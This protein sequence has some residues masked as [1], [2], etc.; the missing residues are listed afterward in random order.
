MDKFKKIRD[1]IFDA[2]VNI[3]T[4]NLLGALKANALE[5]RSATLES[6]DRELSIEKHNLVFIGTIGSG[7]TTALCYILGL[8]DD[9]NTNNTEKHTFSPE[10]LVTGSGGSTICEVH[11]LLNKDNH[12]SIKTEFITKEELEYYVD[13]F[14]DF[15]SS[16]VE[17]ENKK[18][19]ALL[20]QEITRALR[21]ILNLKRTESTDFAIEKYKELG[22]RIL[23]KKFLLE[24]IKS[25]LE[26][27]KQLN[28][29]DTPYTN[30]EFIKET[31]KLINSAALPQY[32]IPK[33]ITILLNFE[34]F[35]SNHIWNRYDKVID[36]K[37]L[38]GPF[39]RPDIEKYFKKSKNI[40]AFTSRFSDA[41]DS[42]IVYQIEKC[43]EIIKPKSVRK[44]KD[45]AA[46]LVLPRNDEPT[47]KVGAEGDYD[48]GLTLARDYISS[49]IS[50]IEDSIKDEN[51]LFF[52]A[53]K[54][55]DVKH[56]TKNIIEN[57]NNITIQSRSKDELI[58][59]IDSEIDSIT[60]ITSINKE[61][62]NS[63]IN[64]L[65]KIGLSEFIVS[66]LEFGKLFSEK[67][68]EWYPHWNTKHAINK[69]KGVWGEY[70]VFFLAKKVFM[71]SIS[72]DL[73]YKVSE[74]NKY[75]GEINQNLSPLIHAIDDVILSIELSKF[76]IRLEFSFLDRLV[77][78]EF[79]PHKDFWE[80]LINH[81]IRGHGYTE[82]VLNK[83][84]AQLSK[85]L[86]N[87]YQKLI[88]EKWNNLIN[89][90]LDKLGYNFVQSEVEH[91]LDFELRSFQIQ[92]FQGIN[93]TSQVIIPENSKCI[94]L[95]GE[96]GYGKTSILRGIAAGFIGK[97]E[98][99]YLLVESETTEIEINYYDRLK[100]R[101]IST[102][103]DGNSFK[104]IV[105]YG[106]NRNGLGGIKKNS[107][108]Y[109]LFYEDGDFINI[110]E[111]LMKLERGNEEQIVYYTSIRK[112]LLDFLEDYIDDIY[113]H[114]D[115]TDTKVKYKEKGSNDY[116]G[117]EQLATGFKSVIGLVGDIIWRLAKNNYANLRALSGIVIIDEFDLHLH[118]KW[119]KNILIKLNKTF[120]KVQ[121]IISTHS[122][123]PFLG[124]PINSTI[125]EIDRDKNANITASTL[126]N[127]DFSRLQP[128]AI[129][130]S[131]IFKF[132]S[133]IPHS[134]QGD[135]YPE[136]ED[137]HSNID[138]NRQLEN[139][140]SE[141][142]DDERTKEIL[143]AI[144][145]SDD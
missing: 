113:I 104:H 41:P 97:S 65:K 126:E 99:N 1:K 70:N 6:I 18:V 122:P 117:Y 102:T 66:D 107:R 62:E 81:E 139:D 17:P 82:R 83:Y 7:K 136:T 40:L 103:L 44:L 54:Q 8:T 33:R 73:N 52:N 58:N 89:I 47:K 31:F 51:I 112:I 3:D 90:I 76:K 4:N 56:K 16:R 26:G 15:I 130:T 119:Q 14:A 22:S 129:L 21:N 134:H 42:N 61:E 142:L 114:R 88:S 110:E 50:I 19:G 131:K 53:K 118:P 101:E 100:D 143:E 37:G 67:F 60:S 78:E 144:N 123:I 28:E 30:H 98:D 63:L 64:A 23:F 96:N 12:S 84:T 141:Y 27:E 93:N 128:N 25:V 34:L 68:D 133:L 35:G 140:V 38:D 124:A 127:I 111:E 36:T 9:K 137:Y 115:G 85:T 72:K 75:I 121:F 71:E 59:F 2:N 132:K 74:I 109:H 11:I 106:A 116:I 5:G 43:A 77:Q 87:F 39:G 10:L 92:N 29:S 120:P 69:R 94:F 55:D 46:I 79:A 80:E 57:F 108:A 105:A 45:R 20:P 86:F 13:D 95:T 138:L 49:R 145:K 24:N 32:S 135:K 91:E 48:F 125:I